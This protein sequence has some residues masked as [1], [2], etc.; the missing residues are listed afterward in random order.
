MS[1]ATLAPRNARPCSLGGVSGRWFSSSTPRCKQ[2]LVIL[3]SGW[4]GYNILRS[5]DKKRW[6]EFAGAWSVKFS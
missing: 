2:R 6:G 4:G 3:G 5:V 1:L